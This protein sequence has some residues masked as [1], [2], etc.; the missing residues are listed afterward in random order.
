[1]TIV[2]DQ[3]GEPKK[4]CEPERREVFGMARSFGH[5][6]RRAYIVALGVI[7][8]LS[9][10]AFLV[11]DTF[12][13]SQSGAASVIGVASRQLTL[14][15]RIVSY[16][17]SLVRREGTSL[18]NQASKERDLYYLEETIEEMEQAHAAL[19]IGD[20]KR[21]LPGIRS[22]D[23][24]A[25]YDEAPHL[26]SNRLR[27]FL[28]DAR[29]ILA[30]PDGP[31]ANGIAERVLKAAQGSLGRALAAVVTHHE[32]TARANALLAERIHLSLL[33][34]TLAILA[35]EG[36]VIFRPLVRELA[37]TENTLRE[38]NAELTHQALHDPLTGIMNRRGLWRFVDDTTRRH[39]TTRKAVLMIDIDNFK[40]INDTYGHD[41]GD[42]VLRVVAAALVD[43]LRKDDR[44]FRVGGDEFMVITTLVKR[45]VLED[46]DHDSESV[47]DLDEQ[48]LAMAGRLQRNLDCRLQEDER[49]ALASISIGCASSPTTAYGLTE[50]ITDA[51]LA[52]YQAK[53]EGRDRIARYEPE[54][55][56]RAQIRQKQDSFLQDALERDAFE[57]F[58]QPQINLR[59]GKV[60]GVEA[61]A[62]C[63]RANSEL[64]PPF[65]FLEAAERTK[66]I[67]PVG[68][69]VIAKAIRSA[70]NWLERGIDFG[71]LSI[72]ASAA[73]LRDPGFVP[74]LKATLNDAGLPTRMLS[75][76]V[77]ESVLLDSRDDM[78]T[79]T[80]DAIRD[81]GATIELDDFGTGYAS[82][83]NIDRLGVK[84]IKIDRSVLIQSTE[85]AS[86][87]ILGAI[88][89]VARSLQLDVLVEGVET[90]EQVARLKA[91][92]CRKAQ[93][94]LFARPM[95]ETE[96]V[97]WFNDQAEGRHM[98]SPF[99]A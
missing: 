93:G 77:L 17:Q 68:E 72:N 56:K 6:I 34:A 48:M 76:E 33:I 78:I 10:C 9:V 44:C 86:G 81:M 70:A 54:L 5:R 85:R 20:S 40:L 7:A 96:V 11:L 26:V 14:S 63:R 83:A 95:P 64:V 31:N 88:I 32:T 24:R 19:T 73:Q 25:F 75:V 45:D 18:N 94:F 22:A 27:Y 12:I 8:V 15:Q 69:A 35:F 79:C 16:T 30:E 29:K 62:R 99:V 49:F 28:Q 46:G 89:A 92:G 53:A 55:R 80:C 51:D 91:L 21:S 23:E 52:L 97:E 61:L 87:D 4:L 38:K 58:F 37:Q 84:Q 47:I 71:Q 98:A 41:A 66:L 39:D 13:A 36:A 82:I 3:N 74:F 67:V 59:T 60:I 43:S 57:A 2:D 50:L 1:M 42:A 90:Q 65:E